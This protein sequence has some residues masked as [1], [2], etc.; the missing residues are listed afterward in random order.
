[1]IQDLKVINHFFQNKTII[2][3]GGCGFIGSNL[4]IRFLKNTN[5]KIVNID[6][7]SY[8]SD[9]Y[10]IENC[11][12]DNS[13]SRTGRYEFL[14]IDLSNYEF[15]KNAIEKS[16]PDLI[17]HLAAE[18]HVDRSIDNPKVFLQSNVVGT[19][20]LL[21]AVKNYYYNLNASKKTDFRF[22]HISTDEVFG[23]LDKEGYFSELTRYSPRSPYSASKAA[24][25]H[26]V[27]AWF[28]TYGIPTLIT[29]CSNNFG[30]WQFIEKFIPLI[31]T[32]ALEGKS[33]PIYGK[34]SNIR[35]WLYVEDHIDALLLV[36]SKG[37]IGKSY[38][39][40]S[41]NEHTNLQLCKKICSLMNVLI[42]TNYSYEKLIEFVKDRPGHDQRYSIDSKLLSE[43]L[44]WRPKYSFDESL[45]ITVK[46]YIENIKWC[47][48]IKK[49]SGYGGER[50]GL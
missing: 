34:G 10:A 22:H 15:T 45:K 38:C 46:W 43:E 2:V 17:F 30:P 24:S 27:N 14:N 31:I 49:K 11:L 28:H 3:T 26:F 32:K 37:S 36:V 44:G 25:D 13:I 21:E 50:I 5:S 7:L 20:N 23:S 6:K 29:N 42:P 47:Q 39:I 4:I 1:M 41:S 9:T 35:D 12:K 8:A 16:K 48:H 19:F 18:S 40:G 33:I